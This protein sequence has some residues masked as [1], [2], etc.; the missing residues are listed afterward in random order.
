MTGTH[1]PEHEAIGSDIP[2][3]AGALGGSAIVPASEEAALTVAND[4]GLPVAFT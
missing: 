2:T 4:A 3:G 1:A